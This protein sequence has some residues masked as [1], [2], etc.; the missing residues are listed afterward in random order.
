MEHLTKATGCLG[1]RKDTAPLFILL[2]TFIKGSGSETRPVGTES[3]RAHS[4]EASIKD[5]GRMMCKKD[6]EWKSGERIKV[7]MKVSL[8][9]G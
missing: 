9:K 6:M 8:S 4:T 3:I 7:S 1:E 2:E 5:S